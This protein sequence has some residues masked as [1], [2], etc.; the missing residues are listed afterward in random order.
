MTIHKTTSNKNKVISGFAG[1]FFTFTSLLSWSFA[2]PVAAGPDEGFHL[3]TIWCS[4]GIRTGICQLDQN[5]EKAVPEMVYN[6]CFQHDS[7][8]SA[9][10]IYGLDENSWTS[11][12]RKSNPNLWFKFLSLFA[13]D[14]I[15]VRVLVIRALSIFSILLLGS[16]VFRLLDQKSKKAMTISGFL[17][18]IPTGAYLLSS[19]HPSGVA[20]FAVLFG[21]FSL[22][23]VTTD[24]F[25]KN[26]KNIFKLAILIFLIIVLLGSVRKEAFIFYIAFGFLYVIFRLIEKIGIKNKI[27]L[28]LL[29]I[30]VTFPILILLIQKMTNLR[31]VPNSF[32]IFE[33]TYGEDR[34]GWNVLSTNLMNFPDLMVGNFGFWGLGSLDVPLPDLIWSLIFVLFIGIV[35]INLNYISKYSLLYFAITMFSVAALIILVLQS[36]KLYVGEEL[37][38]RYI[39]PLMIIGFSVYLVNAD[40]NVFKKNRNFLFKN[41]YILFLTIANCIALWTTLRRYTTGIDVGE[42]NLY[43]GLEW[44]WF[45]SNR[46]F[47]EY[48]SPNNFWALGTISVPL[49]MIFLLRTSGQDET[50]TEKNLVK[51]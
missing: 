35:A 25:N 41:I 49:A 15:D 37:Q 1:L 18:M 19:A 40:L 36:S 21:I 12:D 39:L 22:H 42:L 6:W 38:P 26:Y 5:G 30:S 50:K 11:S 16:L 44:W 45:L 28:R 51:P 8:L 13:G 47:F 7:T 32:Q 48:A 43:K 17:L 46:T 27:T 4:N 10:C 20:A 34:P 29:L 14:P 33:V 3:A 24:F 23:Q 9:S 31:L 2:S